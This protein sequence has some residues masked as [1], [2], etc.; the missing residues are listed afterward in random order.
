M[1]P[2]YLVEMT[3]RVARGVALAACIPALAALL[4]AASLA[5][6]AGQPAAKPRCSARIQ[7][8]FWP[9]EANHDRDLMRKMVQS[10]DLEV[11]SLQV[12]KYRWKPVSINVARE[13]QKRERKAGDDAAGDSDAK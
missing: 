1:A 8:Q 2:Q 10:G 3:K 7:G 13:M 6:T 9:E 5:A 4:P 12:W 11:C